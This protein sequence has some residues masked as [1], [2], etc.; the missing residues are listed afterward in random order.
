MGGY[1]SQSLDDE[2]A[3]SAAKEEEVEKLEKKRKNAKASR[4]TRASK[5]VRRNPSELPKAQ[6]REKILVRRLVAATSLKDF[7]LVDE[8]VEIERLP[9]P[10][11][12]DDLVVAEANDPRKPNEQEERQRSSIWKD[13]KIRSRKEKLCLMRRQADKNTHKRT[14]MR[15]NKR[16]LMQEMIMQLKEVKK[17]TEL[18]SPTRLE[19][20]K[21]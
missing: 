12:Q 2:E 20:N 7:D 17:K 15:N 6:V 3:S 18:R 8:V 10:P 1:E 11:S 14:R 9:T 19:S 5:R 13:L 4:G 21:H 16:Q